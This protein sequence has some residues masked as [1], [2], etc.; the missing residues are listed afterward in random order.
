MSKIYPSRWEPAHPDRLQLYSMAT[1]NGQKIGIALE[2]LGLPY[3]AHKIDITKGDQFDPEY[4]ALVSPGSKIPAII[5]PHGPGEAPLVLMESGAIL[6][7][8]AG[9]GGGLFPDDER[10]RWETKKWLFFSVGNVG[11][12]LGQFGHFFMFARDKVKD[13]YPLERYTGIAQHFLGVLDRRLEDR[14]FLAGDEFTIADVCTLP[15]INAL[16]FYEGKDHIGY[17]SYTSVQKWVERCMARPAVQRGIKV[18]A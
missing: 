5:D 14:T 11:P 2:E 17:A 3:E 6:L 9:K 18:C 1:P 7:Y 16:D 13:D 15:W 10:L 8:L 4:I 12:M